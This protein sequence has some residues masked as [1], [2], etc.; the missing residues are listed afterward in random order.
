MQILHKKGRIILLFFCLI[1]FSQVI[2]AQNISD[3]KL[4]IY[5]KFKCCACQLSFDKCSCPEAKEMKVYIDALIESGVSKDEIFYKVARKY[6]L[7]ALLDK[8]IKANIEE[9]LIKEAGER[10][11]QISMD[12]A[13]FD[14]GRV[15]KK[16]GKISKIFKLSNTG[17]SHLIINNI[18]TSCP[19]AGVS[20]KTDGIKSAFFSIEGSPKDWLVEIAPNQD[21]EI[22]LMVDLASPH[23]KTGKLIR[24]AT[25]ASND[26]VYPEVTV[27]IEAEVND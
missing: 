7:N 14:F 8:Q 25:I 17:N 26:P 22:E 18:K 3:L 13:S 6:S 9:R 4:E 20:L 2:F 1:F 23:V 24:E 19:C 27:R 10:R 15:S 12:V 21:A 5:P 16:D 11:P